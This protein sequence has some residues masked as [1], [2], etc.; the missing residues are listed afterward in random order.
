MVPTS[1]IAAIER[2]TAQNLAD[3]WLKE[4]EQLVSP[5]VS[6]QKILSQSLFTPSCGCGSLPELMAE[7]VVQLTRE[8]STIMK[9]QL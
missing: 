2:E 3:R 1:D 5:E 8:L 9:S 6:L 4:L 7:R